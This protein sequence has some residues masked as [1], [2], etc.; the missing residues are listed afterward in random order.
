MIPFLGF[1]PMFWIKLAIVAG[2]FAAGA[3]TAHQFHKADLVAQVNAA[4]AEEQGRFKLVIRTETEVQERII[5]VREKGKEIIREIPVIVTKE[6]EK[7][8]PQGMPHGF[9]RL[10]DAAA[11][12]ATPGPS[13]IPDAAPA[14][15]T[16]AQTSSTI[17]D[18]YTECHV[19]REQ[20]I[21][22][23]RY[24]KALQERER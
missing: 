8:C 15:V 10:H 5:K 12:N 13:P 17:T 19:W 2:A 3:W 14:G 16:I 24:Y 11:R 9:V 21:G 4:R 23:Q 1:S 18:N 7:A 22:W 20:V 6:V